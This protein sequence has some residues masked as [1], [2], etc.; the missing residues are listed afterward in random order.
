[1]ENNKFDDVKTL[2]N[3][4]EPLGIM[5]ENCF[6]SQISAER[7][8]Q[9]ITSIMSP[10]IREEIPVHKYITGTVTICDGYFSHNI[11]FHST[12]FTVHRSTSGPLL[13][14]KFPLEK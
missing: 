2:F 14:D 12:G 13:L 10:E 8:S 6:V 7:V 3:Q 9:I 5:F 4:K 1:V 11:T